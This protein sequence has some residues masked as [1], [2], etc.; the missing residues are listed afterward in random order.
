MYNNKSASID[1]LSIIAMIC[2]LYFRFQ[3]DGANKSKMGSISN[4]PIS[5]QMVSTNLLK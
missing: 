5:M 2:W 1:A 3:D 4:R